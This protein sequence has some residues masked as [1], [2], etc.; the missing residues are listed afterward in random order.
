MDA[1]P[2]AP[3]LKLPIGA[4][5]L[6]HAGLIALF[7]FYRPSP[8]PPGPPVYSVQLIAA[9]PGPRAI[10]TVQETAPKSAPATPPPAPR[11]RPA[12]VEK[13]IPAPP[14]TKARPAPAPRQATPVPPAAKAAPATPGAKA[15][16]AGGGPEGGRGA[17]VANV[18]IGGIAF[19]FPGYLQNIVRQIAVRFH[20][21][22][23]GVLHAEVF[24]LIHRDGTVSGFRFQKRS[25]VYAFDIEA[26]G[27]V[28]AAADARAFGPLPGGFPDDVLPVIFTFDPAIIR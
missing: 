17:D 27:A 4:S 9:P 2:A 3:S 12:P 13:S 5:V 26:Q 18:D 1:R 24:F 25:G 8:P 19:P 15:P 28:E 6:L 7:V 23:R 21:P 22:G 10:G 14:T 20:P 16:A 11:K